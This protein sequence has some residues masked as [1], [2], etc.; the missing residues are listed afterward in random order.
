MCFVQCCFRSRA[1]K[2]T[3]DILERML[4]QGFD[5]VCSN[6]GTATTIC[7]LIFK[8]NPFF[9]FW[10]LLLN[11]VWVCI[12]VWDFIIS[13]M[14]TKWNFYKVNGFFFRCLNWMNYCELLR[15][16]FNRTHL[17]GLPVKIYWIIYSRRCPREGERE[18][19]HGVR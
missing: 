5:F 12:F 19:V 10:L 4:R 14:K 15:I 9:F 7:I 18:R 8:L 1:S 11:F 2:R 16:A 17:Y 3:V 13:W 6:D